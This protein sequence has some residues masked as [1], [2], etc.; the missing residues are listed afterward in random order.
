M[1]TPRVPGSLNLILRKWTVRLSLSD[2]FHSHT[3]LVGARGFPGWG[4]K[5]WPI[6]SLFRPHLGAGELILNNGEGNGRESA[7]SK[8]LDV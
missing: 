3:Q 8:L 4:C 6:S 7:R 2:V 1:K 5:P